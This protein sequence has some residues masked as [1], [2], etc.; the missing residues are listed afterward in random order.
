MPQQGFERQVLVD[1]PDS[2]RLRAV[3]QYKGLQELHVAC[4][5]VSPSSAF[6]EID[7]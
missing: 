2:K 7:Q 5:A 3:L 6:P 1:G 4:R